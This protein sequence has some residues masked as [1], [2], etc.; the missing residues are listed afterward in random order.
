VAVSQQIDS[1]GEQQKDPPVGGPFA[2]TV[3]VSGAPFGTHMDMSGSERNQPV[4]DSAEKLRWFSSVPDVYV[5][6]QPKGRKGATVS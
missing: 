6:K 4:F 1:S 2:W 3:P 5:Q